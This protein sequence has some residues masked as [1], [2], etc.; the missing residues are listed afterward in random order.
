MVTIE[1]IK[2]VINKLNHSSDRVPYTYHHDYLIV[3][4]DRFN[5]ASRSHVAMS[6]DDSDIELY[7]CSLIQI[8]NDQSIETI[9]DM[10]STDVIICQK[11]VKTANY[12]LSKY[13]N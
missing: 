9:L 13:N 2:S 3:K 10:D 11:A 6:H 5:N 4:T 1:E 7:A 8:L 12:V